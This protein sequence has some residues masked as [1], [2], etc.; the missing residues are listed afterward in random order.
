MIN[1]KEYTDS[2]DISCNCKRS[3]ILI[4]LLTQLHIILNKIVWII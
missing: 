2:N 4:E 1:Y 3:I